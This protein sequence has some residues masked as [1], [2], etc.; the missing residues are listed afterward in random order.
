M[1]SR[2]VVQQVQQ[3][4]VKPILS[5]SS[6][7]A[8]RRVMS[9]YRAWYRQIPYILHNESYPLTEKMCRDKLREVFY[10]NS[11]VTDTRVIDMM[12]I[13]GQMEL[14]ETVLKFKQQCH[15]LKYFNDTIQPRPKDFISRFL[16]GKDSE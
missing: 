8:K 14:T 13:K 1:A 16:G 2:K 4:R 10:R 7:E 3:G 5:A 6:V 11:N 12:V 15:L 9:L